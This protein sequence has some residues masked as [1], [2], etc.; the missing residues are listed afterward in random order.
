M[1]LRFK[2]YIYHFFRKVGEFLDAE[3]FAANI[4]RQPRFGE[5]GGQL[6]LVRAVAEHGGERVEQRFAPLCERGPNQS[7]KQ[8]LVARVDRRNGVGVHPHDG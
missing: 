7:E 6:R 5:D 2:I 4:R 3:L 8:L 1:F